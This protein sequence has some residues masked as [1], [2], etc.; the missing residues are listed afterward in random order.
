MVPPDELTAAVPLQI[1]LQVALVL[2]TIAELNAK[3]SIIVAV[4][5]E[6]QSLASKMVRAVDWFD[7]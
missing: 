7:N 2:I 6:W 1:P 3:G 5:K 4:F